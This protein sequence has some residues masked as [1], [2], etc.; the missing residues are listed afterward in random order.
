MSDEDTA[1]RQAAPR[2]SRWL[3]LLTA[4]LALFQMGAVI[5]A[6]QLPPDLALQLPFSPALNMVAGVI[7]SLIALFITLRL[8]QQQPGAG[9]GAAWL[10]AAF[11]VYT[12]V[13]L[14]LFTRADY[15]LGRLP[16]LLVVSALLICIPVVSI[17]RSGRA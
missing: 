15:D 10:W 2:R 9:Q 5:Y 8:I 17:A 3:I 6:L 13:R 12:V 7:W 16:F 11:G 14:V 4:L 1:P